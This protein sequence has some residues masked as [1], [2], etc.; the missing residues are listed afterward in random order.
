ML[1]VKLVATNFFVSIENLNRSVISNY[2][3]LE[4]QKLNIYFILP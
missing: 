4:E 3:L 1:N 2:N